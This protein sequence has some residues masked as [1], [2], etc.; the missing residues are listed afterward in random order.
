[1]Y[2]SAASITAGLAP[3]WGM[4]PSVGAVP[5][6][7]PGIDGISWI[8]V[9]TITGGGSECLRTHPA[10]ISAPTARTNEAARRIMVP[11]AIMVFP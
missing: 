11:S 3:D 6:E 10:A 7:A 1:M 4:A 2:G 9:A 5:W 8:V